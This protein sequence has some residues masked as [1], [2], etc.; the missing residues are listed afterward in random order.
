[1]KVADPALEEAEIDSNI[2]SL[3]ME[4]LQARVKE[5]HFQA[6]NRVTEAREAGFSELNDSHEKDVEDALFLQKREY[7]QQLEQL[8]REGRRKE[9]ESNAHVQEA[10]R[11]MEE[12]EERLFHIT[13]GEQHRQALE[14]A[15]SL[16]TSLIAEEESRL[17]LEEQVREQLAAAAA[18]EQKLEEALLAAVARAVPAEKKV[19]RLRRQLW[20]R[21]RQLVKKK[22]S[23]QK[24][25]TN[26]TELELDFQT[27]CLLEDRVP[28]GNG[29]CR[30][31][32]ARKEIP[33]VAEL[34]QGTLR[35]SVL[36]AMQILSPMQD[37][38]I[39]RMHADLCL[40][41]VSAAA[42]DPC[43]TSVAFN[44]TSWLA[45][46]AWVSLWRCVW[47]LSI[48]YF[49][50]CLAQLVCFW[51]RFSNWFC[52]FSSKENLATLAI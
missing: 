16:A 25:D 22:P 48:R 36:E 23:T 32:K 45:A 20:L 33:I 28:A 15:D 38:A 26:S 43:N 30:K 3:S 40:A 19:S 7:N 12:A 51:D 9:A 13:S 24:V 47:V 8:R 11:R 37:S 2:S 44:V 18:R 39:W 46:F 49:I 42:D 34:P 50:S 52:G 31:K 41:Q 1:L 21:R 27:Q 6:E 4:E 29:I 17:L 5:C 10:T 14:R 35:Q